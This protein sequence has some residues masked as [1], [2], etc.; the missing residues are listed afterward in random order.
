[1]AN[2]ICAILLLLAGAVLAYFT[3]DATLLI[4]GILIAVP[5]FFAKEKHTFY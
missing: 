4:F 3:K 2:R 1:M 5:L